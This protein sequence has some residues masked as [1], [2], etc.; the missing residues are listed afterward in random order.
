M[1]TSYANEDSL[2]LDLL[3]REVDA[4]DAAIVAAVEGRRKLVAHVA[5]L[6]RDWGFPARDEER[7]GEVIAGYVRALDGRDGAAELGRA[8][9]FASRP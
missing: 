7:E 1:A 2:A 9:L 4:A 8:V 5:R 3:R 6:K